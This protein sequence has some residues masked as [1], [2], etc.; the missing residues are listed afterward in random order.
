M[1]D[2]VLVDLGFGVWGARLGL[3]FG[4]LRFRDVGFGM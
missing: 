3:G 1:G 2:E 4:D